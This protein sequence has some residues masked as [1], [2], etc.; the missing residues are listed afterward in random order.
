MK[1]KKS[2]ASLEYMVM[3]ALSLGIFVAILYVATSLISTASSHIGID[4]AYRAVQEIREKADFIYIHG[5]PSKTQSNV[6]ISPSV[7]NVS[8]NGKTVRIR[9]SV[10]HS[11]TDIYAITKGQLTGDLS[12]IKREG[13]YVLN[14]ESTPND[15]VNITCPD[16]V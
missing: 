8:I 7:E 6:Y 2:Q 10:D 15:L 4:S 11:Y 1:L 14:I 13:Y 3:L 5:H 9:V 16:C 12:S